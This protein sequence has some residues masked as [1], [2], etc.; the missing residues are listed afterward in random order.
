MYIKIF[1]VAD[2]FSL[3]LRENLDSWYYC[4]IGYVIYMRDGGLKVLEL[5]DVV[6]VVTAV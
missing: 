6:V 1:A 5:A 4:R 2:C 3:D